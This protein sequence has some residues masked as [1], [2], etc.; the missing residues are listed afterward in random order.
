[1]KNRDFV[2]YISFGEIQ[3]G[4]DYLAVRKRLNSPFSQVYFDE[5]A[6]TFSDYFDELGFKME[7]DLANTVLS[8]ETF[9]DMSNPFY[10]L[11]SN[12]TPM[13]YAQ[14]EQLFKANDLNV[15]PFSI[16]FYSPKFGISICYEN[17]EDSPDEITSS[18]HIVRKD[19]MEINK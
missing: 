13:T 7:Y 4:E 2:P 1:M 14:L 8:I 12:L 16:G 15:E 5:N 6:K 18:F 19:Y 9:N 10:F 3:F 17:F 11:S